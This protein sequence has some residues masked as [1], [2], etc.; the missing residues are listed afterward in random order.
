MKVPGDCLLDNVFI[1]VGKIVYHPR[2]V[3]VV[4]ICLFKK[5]NKSLFSLMSYV[6]AQEVLIKDTGPALSTKQCSTS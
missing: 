6:R 4:L 1:F 3:I 2:L 5:R